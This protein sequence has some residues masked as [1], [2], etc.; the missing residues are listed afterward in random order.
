MIAKCVHCGKE[1]EQLGWERKCAHNCPL[2][3]KK[4]NAKQRNL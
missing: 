3:I 2:Y 1:F 4:Q